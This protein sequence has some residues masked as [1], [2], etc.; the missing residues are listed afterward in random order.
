[1]TWSVRVGSA[2]WMFGVWAAVCC[3]CVGLWDREKGAR[4]AVEKGGGATEGGPEV[5]YDPEFPCNLPANL[6]TDNN[7]YR[8]F[9]IPASGEVNEARR[10]HTYSRPCAFE[11]KKRTLPPPKSRRTQNTPRNPQQP[12]ERDHLE[13]D[14][15]S[16]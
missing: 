10:P 11:E 2:V 8:V 9:H 4:T 5:K 1:M 15:S 12:S 6:V 3:G 13:T 14:V 7:L 16:R